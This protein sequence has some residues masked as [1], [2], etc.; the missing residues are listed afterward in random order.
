MTVRWFFFF[1]FNDTATPEIY[2]L[3]LHDA[4]PISVEAAL[5]LARGVVDR[6]AREIGEKEGDRHESHGRDEGEDHE[7]LGQGIAVLRPGAEPMHVG[8]VLPHWCRG[9]SPFGPPTRMA[10][11]GYPPQALETNG[12]SEQGVCRTL[13]SA[14]SRIYRLT[15]HPPLAVRSLRTATLCH[16]ARHG[17]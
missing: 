17:P 3:S 6:G 10:P 4:L 13:S 14:I 5:E 2:T 12:L 9:V 11:Q 15:G 16:P 8:H 1:F 7:E